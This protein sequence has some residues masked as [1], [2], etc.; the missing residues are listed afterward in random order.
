M[1][2]KK[3]MK[4]P[5]QSRQFQKQL[6]PWLLT[7]VSTYCALS[8][9][10]WTSNLWSTSTQEPPVTWLQKINV[11]SLWHISMWLN[12]T[13]NYGIYTD[14]NEY[15]GVFM[16]CHR[17]TLPRLCNS[18]WNGVFSVPSRAV[19]S[20]ASPRL[21]CLQ[22]RAIN[23]CITQ[24]RGR[25]TWPCQ[26]WHNNLS[27]SRMS[28]QGF[29]GKTEAR[30][31]SVLGSRQLWMIWLCELKTSSVSGRLSLCNIWSDLKR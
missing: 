21:V 13:V 17:N 25:V 22:A 3:V 30:L 1:M 31:R 5:S 4:T 7:A 24:E 26:Q 28:N 2:L 10:T 18:R 15:C 11:C 9:S 14:I 12:H 27:V 8:C 16:P 6:S 29:I 23:T 20:H 19:T